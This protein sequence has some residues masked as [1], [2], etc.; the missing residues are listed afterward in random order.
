ML[1][2]QILEQYSVTL[3]IGLAL[4]HVHVTYLVLRVAFQRYPRVLVWDFD[5]HL[6]FLTFVY[7]ALGS[8]DEKCH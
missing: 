2:A 3:A 8:Q 5:V 7:S 4:L 1:L 6:V